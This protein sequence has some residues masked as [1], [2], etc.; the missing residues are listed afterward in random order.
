[1][2]KSQENYFSGLTFSGNGVFKNVYI[3]YNFFLYT[4]NEQSRV[5]SLFVWNCALNMVEIFSYQNL[6]I[7][8]VKY[9]VIFT[10]NQQSE[11][12]SRKVFM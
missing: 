12:L 10:N 8:K 6:V 2:S 4:F 1:M 9:C 7:R 5:H 11:K 3:A